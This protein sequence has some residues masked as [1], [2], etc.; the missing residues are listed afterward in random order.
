MDLSRH[1]HRKED[2]VW[3]IARANRRM[4]FITILFVAFIT[5]SS[6]SNLI[7]GWLAFNTIAIVGGVWVFRTNLARFKPISKQSLVQQAIEEE[8]QHRAREH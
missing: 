1:E 8:E 7:L 5:Q 2:R 6:I 3:R 4:M